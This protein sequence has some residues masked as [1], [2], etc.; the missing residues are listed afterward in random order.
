MAYKETPYDE[1]RR[2]ARA[3]DRGRCAGAVNPYN[4]GTKAHEDY[5]RGRKDYFEGQ[6]RWK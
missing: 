4:K 6:P 2:A 3:I 1:G 5:D